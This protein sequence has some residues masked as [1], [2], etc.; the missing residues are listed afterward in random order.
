MQITSP[1]PPNIPP[2]EGTVNSTTE[3]VSTNLS[4][5]RPP[6]NQS[7]L[8]SAPIFQPPVNELVEDKNI[9]LEME[10][11]NVLSIPPLES[12]LVDNMSMEESDIIE[13]S[14]VTMSSTEFE[15][16]EAEL[17]ETTTESPTSTTLMEIEH[18]KSVNGTTENIVIV[19]PSKID[20][21]DDEDDSESPVSSGAGEEEENTNELR[22]NDTENQ[23]AASLITK[24]DRPS[25]HNKTPLLKSVDASADQER[26]LKYH[27]AIGKSQ[28]N[29]KDSLLDKIPL[30]FFR[31]PQEIYI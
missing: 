7:Q 23:F 22:N 11:D 4:I 16:M 27:F 10:N 31:K 30:A 9:N 18:L 3:E 25:S 24:R 8:Q 14:S 28:K 1:K 13:T 15:L 5:P 6:N 26:T 29:L 21:L 17:E 12:E 20:S 19:T 2:T